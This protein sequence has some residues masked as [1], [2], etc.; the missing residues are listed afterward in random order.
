MNTPSASVAKGRAVK[1][2]PLARLLPAVA[3]AFGALLLAPAAQAVQPASPILTGTNPASPAT[4]L[5][6]FVRGDA[7]GVITSK[8]GARSSVIGGSDSLGGGAMTAATENPDFIITLYTNDLECEAGTNPA[9]SGKAKDLEGSGIQ[10]SN[11]VTPGD[12]TTFFATQTDPADPLTPSDCSKGIAYRHVA[13]PPP[14]PSF[15]Q[16]T[17]FSPADNNTPFVLGAAEKESTVSLYTNSSCSGAPVATGSAAAFNGAG[18]QVSVGDN[19]ET[20]FYATATLAGFVSSCSTASLTYKEET[21]TGGETPG[22]ETPGG[23]TPG[24]GNPGGGDPGGGG[25][26]GPDPKGRPSPPDLRTVPGYAANDNTPTV[27]GRSPGAARVEVYGSA[28]CKGPILAQG[29]AAEFTGPGFDV[30]VPN[31]TVVAFYGVSIDGGDDRS[32]CSE[33]PALYYEDS[34]APHTRI[35]SG[36]AAKTR[37]RKVIFRFADISGDTAANFL[38]KLDRKRWKACRAPLKLKGLGLRSH[39]LKVKAVD[40]AGNVEQGMAKRRFRVVRAY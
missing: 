11:D 23:E 6:P 16:T 3:V 7:D 38:C 20:T 5:K 40:A 36:P 37:K 13:G 28:G 19:T 15:A 2:R 29:P 31:D 8:V 30:Q 12:V 25:S 26:K 1:A 21:E 33:S 17:P 10:V 27:T 18:I 32:L 22:G 24:G 35:T 9:G 39:L 4:A 14:A 34:T